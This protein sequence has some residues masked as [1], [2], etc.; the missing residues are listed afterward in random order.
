MG[1]C[2]ILEGGLY[3]QTI[4]RLTLN[5]VSSFPVAT[6]VFDDLIPLN[7][8]KPG[9]FALVGRILGAAEDVHRLEE[10]GLRNG[11][12]IQMFRPG[13]PC[14]VRMAGNKVCLR[15]DDSLNVLVRSNGTS[16]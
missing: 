16:C 2:G 15:S 10:F 9:Q 13:N 6:P 11:T 4:L 7:R 12:A 1:S 3:F 8:L 14:I 5:F